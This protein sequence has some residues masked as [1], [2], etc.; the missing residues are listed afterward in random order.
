MTSFNKSLSV[1]FAFIKKVRLVE[2]R[3]MVEKLIDLYAGRLPIAATT[4]RGLALIAL[5]EATT[6][7]VAYTLCI[8]NIQ[9]IVLANCV[10]YF[11]NHLYRINFL[12][13]WSAVIPALFTLAYEDSLDLLQETCASLPPLMGLRATLAITCRSEQGFRAH[14]RARACAR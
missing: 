4:D 8:W 9:K 14:I 3:W 5:I 10:R 11:G 1:A 13:T 6:P 12:G 2:Y 7:T